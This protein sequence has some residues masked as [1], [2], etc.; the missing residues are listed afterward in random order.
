LAVVYPSPEQTIC[1]R[2]SPLTAVL[3]RFNAIL[4]FSYFSG[5][6]YVVC[7]RVNGL[8]PPLIGAAPMNVL[9]IS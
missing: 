7:A 9:R 3:G 5:S 4:L 2:F 8:A 1:L 6:F